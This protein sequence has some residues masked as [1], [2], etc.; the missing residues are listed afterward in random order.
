MSTSA[1]RAVVRVNTRAWSWC[2]FVLET[3]HSRRHLFAGEVAHLI[4]AADLD[5]ANG[6]ANPSAL[7][8]L[9]EG[10]AK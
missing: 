10:L 8:G 3:V 9:F 6:S 7:T 5:T 4:G 1:V 2:P